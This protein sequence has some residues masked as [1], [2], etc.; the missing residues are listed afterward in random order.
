MEWRLRRAEGDGLVPGRGGL[1][2]VTVGLWRR[3]GLPDLRGSSRLPLDVIF[4]WVGRGHLTANKTERLGD[5]SPIFHPACPLR[6]YLHAEAPGARA[7]P[8]SS[9]S[10]AFEGRAGVPLCRFLHVLPRGPLLLELFLCMTSGLC[11]FSPF[12]HFSE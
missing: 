3:A 6:Y 9:G 2:A 5:P 8:D 11:S 4:A 10:A 1:W 12:R 7:E